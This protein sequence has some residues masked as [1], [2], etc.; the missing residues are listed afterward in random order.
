MVFL[1]WLI[2][3][4]RTSFLLWLDN[5]PLCGYTICASSADEH[6]DFL[7]DVSVVSNATPNTLRQVFVW[8]YVF[9]SCRCI[10]RNRISKSCVTLCLT[11]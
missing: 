11:F 3:P 7:H 6:M 5:I 8:T 9:A 4:S 2:S 10:L 1:D